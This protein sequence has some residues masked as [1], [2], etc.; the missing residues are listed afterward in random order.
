MAA[1]ALGGRAL[2]GATHTTLRVQ[3]TV[4][5]PVVRPWCKQYECCTVSRRFQEMAHTATHT[6]AQ[7]VA[8]DAAF[9]ERNRNQGKETHQ[10]MSERQAH[11]GLRIA[12]ALQ[13]EEPVV[14]VGAVPHRDEGQRVI[15][16]VLAAGWVV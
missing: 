10:Q 7:T 6:R 8:H 15:V 11:P 9:R 14:A 1:C 13:D 2:A 16:R 5:I 4:M 12:C 3:Y